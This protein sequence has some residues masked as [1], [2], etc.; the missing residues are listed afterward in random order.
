MAHKAL[1][2]IPSTTKKKKKKIFLNNNIL[3]IQKSIAFKLGEKTFN[4]L[5]D[6]SVNKR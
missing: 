2:S 6:K 4:K 5:V 3:L 1:S